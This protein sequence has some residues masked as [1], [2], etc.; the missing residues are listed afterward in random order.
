MKLLSDG[1]TAVTRDKSLSAQFEHSIGI[2]EDG[3]RDLHA[4]PDGRAQAALRVRVAQACGRPKVAIRW[5]ELHPM[6]ISR[7]SKISSSH[8]ARWRGTGPSGWPRAARRR[9]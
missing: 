9:R 1:W 8:R 6:Q 3:L 7:T 5:Q 4:E 2:T